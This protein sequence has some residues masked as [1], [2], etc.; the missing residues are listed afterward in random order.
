M[1]SWLQGGWFGVNWWLQAST[2][3][4]MGRLVNGGRA[5]LRREAASEGAA[6]G[7]QHMQCIFEQA[8]TVAAF[9][10]SDERSCF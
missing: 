2:A 3:W 8:N 1:A 5:D 10:G 7:V 6:A 4:T 9:A